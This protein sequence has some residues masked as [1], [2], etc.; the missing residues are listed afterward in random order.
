MI[1]QQAVRWLY[2]AF[3][4][5][6]AGC[7]MLGLMAGS[8]AAQSPKAGKKAPK[9]KS[10]P[11]PKNL[12][13]SKPLKTPG[14]VNLPLGSDRN[15]GKP[16]TT[17]QLDEIVAGELLKSGTA[18]GES[19]AGDDVFIRRVYLDVI[20]QLPGPAEI[21][22]Y[23][24]NSDPAKKSKLID[25]LLGEKQFGQHWAHYWRDV[26]NYRGTAGMN[27]QIP[28]RH[29]EQW[30]ADQFNK[31]A[32]WGDTVTKMLTAKGES[33][34]NPQGYFL[35]AHEGKAEEVA[36]ETA[37]IFMGVQI[38]CAQCHDHPN[39]TWKRDQ[40]HELASFF[41]KVTVRPRRQ[42]TSSMG[43]PMA[44]IFERRIEYR[45]PDLK[46]PTSP[47]EVTAP[48][49]LTG[50]AIPLATSDSDRRKALA[51]FVTSKRNTF[52]A[53]AFVNRVWYEFL[54]Y[55]FT[56]P[57]DDLGSQKPVTMPK[58]FDALSKSFASSNYDVK[59]LM[60]TILNSRVYDRKFR[61]VDM[62]YA[63][64]SLFKTINPTRLSSDQIFDAVDWVLGGLED[65]APNLPRRPNGRGNF[66]QVFGF[67]PSSDKNLV[68]GSIPQALVLM[69]NPQLQSRISAKRTGSLLNK[70]LK[71]NT[72]DNE[73]IRM[74]YLR[75]LARKP[76]SEETLAAA[77]FLSEVDSREEAFEDFLWAL[78]NS[79]EFIYKH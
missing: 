41:G 21:E 35:A 11:L 40:F 51:T 30:L 17:E 70:L 16:L 45:K 49:F 56:N 25:K 75:V 42:Q 31:N 63:S 36:G 24:A 18:K 39:D 79:A 33:D 1:R 38:A 28:F 22:E 23:V 57:V 13:Y 76:T 10:D 15:L 67:D 27:R 61:E 8:L 50:Q 53:K 6:G 14:R 32:G 2:S 73:I 37:R 60:K 59:L 9:V 44:E 54:G 71:T 69:N 34:D 65:N 77:S 64:D 20:G 66:K 52:F 47:G 5:T 74:L 62:S 26:V 12:T 43:G 29:C 48:V 58:V 46:D 72:D 68:E 3:R 4:L 78:L 7:L 19:K 55:G